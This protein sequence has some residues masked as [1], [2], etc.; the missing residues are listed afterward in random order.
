MPSTNPIRRKWPRRLLILTLLLAGLCAAMFSTAPATPVAPMPDAVNVGEAKTAAVRLQSLAATRKP[1][2]IALSWSEAATLATLAGRAS[3]IDRIAVQKAGDRLVIQTSVPW[4]FGLW[5]NVAATVTSS[6]DG[7]PPVSLRIGHI[8][9]P[10]IL[11]R[12]AIEGGRWFLNRR[13]AQLPPV[14]I[15]VSKTEISGNMIAATVLLPRWVGLTDA[16]NPATPVDQRLVEAAYCRLSTVQA[17]KPVREFA[18]LLNRAFAG[19]PGTVEANR[20]TLVA[21]AVLLIPD[22]AERLVGEQTPTMRAC[23]APYRKV[24]LLDRPDLPKHWT[25]SA[26]LAASFDSTISRELGT[27]KEISDSGPGGSGFSFIDLSADRS[28][29]RFGQR[30]ADPAT[31]A[32]TARTLATASTET[33]LPVHALALAEGLTEAEFKARFTNTESGRYDTMIARIDRVLDERD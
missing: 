1:G 10:Q 28:G 18:A 20:A 9:L 8:T 16:V 5:F 24:H 25:L 17:K 31:S 30:A 13:G 15:L 22:D 12:W 32:A 11:S 19:Q 26:A 3:K 14:D 21:L 6:G 23:A 7:F 2:P 4:R 29:I 27:W 33:I